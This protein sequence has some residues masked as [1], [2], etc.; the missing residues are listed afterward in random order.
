MLITFYGASDDLVEV[1]GCEGAD[2]FNHYSGAPW[3]GTL[4]APDGAAMVVHLF[5][6]DCWH[7]GVGQVDED[8]P[9]P[10]WPLVFASGPGGGS[11]IPKYSTALTV[12]APDGTRLEN[13]HTPG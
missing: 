13:T 4:V 1:D 11:Q 8:Q 10:S 12:D 9:L 5:Y 2:E 3:R 6:D 7:V